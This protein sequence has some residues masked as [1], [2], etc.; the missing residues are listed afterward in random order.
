MLPIVGDDV[1]ED[2]ALQEVASAFSRTY[3]GRCHIIGLALAS[4]RD[5]VGELGDQEGLP[6]F[7]GLGAGQLDDCR[8]S[9]WHFGRGGRKN[10]GPVFQGL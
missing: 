8:R 1:V 10:A 2:C 6:G 4:V 9:P 3:L 5:P 7:L